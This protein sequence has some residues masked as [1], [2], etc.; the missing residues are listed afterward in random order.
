MSRRNDG[1]QEARGADGDVMDGVLVVDKPAGPTS[2]DVVDRVRRVLRLRRVGHTGTL[3]PFATGVLPLCLGKATRLA[4]FLAAGDKAYA[5][6]VRFGFATTTDDLHGEPL[7]SRQ[8]P[9]LSLEELRDLARRFEGRIEQR[10][11]DYSAKHIGG[12]RM[13]ELARQGARLAP[14]P[15]PV[16]VQRLEVVS[17]SA[18]CAEILVVCSAGTYIRALGRDLGEALGSGAHLVAL[19]RTRVGAFDMTAA[20]AWDDLD[21]QA[22]QRVVPLS[23]LLMELP[24]AVVGAEGLLALGHGRALSRHMVLDGFPD[25][26]ALPERMCIRDVQGDLIAM[27]V[28]RGA[29]VPSSSGMP[30]ET[31]LHPDVV[32]LRV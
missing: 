11:P 29:T 19:R 22:H 28:P 2:H 25:A 8:T 27:A 21:T 23:A 14:R 31:V 32:L 24:A 9:T 16:H 7:G 5:A 4:R 18:D 30:L 10:P 17:V 1:P 6:T 20:I 13:Y 3:D 12:K 15:V 26:S